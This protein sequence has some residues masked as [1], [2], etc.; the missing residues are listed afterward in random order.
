MFW[1][2]QYAYNFPV[3]PLFDIDIIQR[4][5]VENQWACI[6]FIIFAVVDISWSLDR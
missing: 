6:P 1:H 3:N 5:V 4:A 2:E